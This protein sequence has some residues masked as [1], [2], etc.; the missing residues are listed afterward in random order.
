M[1]NNTGFTLIELMIVLSIIA[2]LLTFGV[3]AYR[4]YVQTS[5]RGVLAK[6]VSSIAVFQEEYRLRRGVYAQDLANLAAITAEIGWDPR[7]GDGITYSIS[8]SEDPAVYQVTAVEGDL[9]ICIEFPVG[10]PCD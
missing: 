3:P 1:K 7:T 9:T 2:I 10:A 6:N 4:D 5:E 8:D